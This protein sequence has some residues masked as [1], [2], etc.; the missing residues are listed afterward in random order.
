MNDCVIWSAFAPSN[1]TVAMKDVVYKGNTYQIHNEMYPFLLSEVSSW[2]CGLSNITRQ[3][4]SAN[5]DR[6]LAKWIAEH[7]LSD[8]AKELLLKAKCL[9]QCVYANLGNIRWLD[10]KIELWDIGWY[11]I[12]EAAKAI[13][14]AVPLLEDVRKCN[15]ELANKILPQISQYGFLPPDIQY[16]E[17]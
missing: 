16:F 10:Y 1:G 13:P 17:E 2:K 7:D 3:I 12:K 11:Q 15:R 5:E 6:F 9:Y 8:D 4:F 14:D